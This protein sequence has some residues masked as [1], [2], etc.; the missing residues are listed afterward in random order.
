MITAE[1]ET[2]TFG[3]PSWPISGGFGAWWFA[4]W[5]RTLRLSR[6]RSKHLRLCESL[7]L[8]DRRFVAVVEFERA[9]FLLGGTASSLVLLS[10]LEDADRGESG[11]ERRG[12]TGNGRPGEKC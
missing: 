5:R 9:R 4:L 10:R 12:E 6:R 2:E 8:G 1:T 3:V 11:D 7:A